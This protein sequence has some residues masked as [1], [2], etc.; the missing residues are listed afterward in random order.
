MGCD[1]LSPFQGLSYFHPTQGLRP[2]LQSFAALRLW[3]GSIIQ[4]YFD[5][6]MGSTSVEGCCASCRIVLVAETKLWANFISSPV[7][8]LRSKRGKLLLEISR[9]NVCPFRKTLLVAQ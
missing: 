3:V 8:R 9:R 4:N 1:F 2:G 5:G 6:M 7:F